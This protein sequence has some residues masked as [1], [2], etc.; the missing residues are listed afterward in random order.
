MFKIV[1]NC[2]NKY[3]RSSSKMMK[4]IFFWQM[5]IPCT[6][7]TQTLDIPS[8]EWM[9]MIEDLEPSSLLQ[10]QEQGSIK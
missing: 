6:L 9:E 5:V 7:A 1:T 4:N 8:S 2:N 3:N 10:R